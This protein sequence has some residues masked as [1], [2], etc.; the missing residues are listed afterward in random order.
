MLANAYPYFRCLRENW[1][2]Y[3]DK[4][5]LDLDEHILFKNALFVEV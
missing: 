3:N 4:T 1:M 2:I 5:F